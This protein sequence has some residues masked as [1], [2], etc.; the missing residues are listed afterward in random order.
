MIEIEAA[1]GRKFA[2]YQTAPAE[3]AKGTVILLGEGA[4]NFADA[5][6]GNGF[7]ALVPMP[8]VDEGDDALGQAL[9]DVQACV[10]YAKGKGKIAVVG[11]GPGGY[12]AYRAG[13]DVQGIACTIGYYAD[14]VAAD[15][16][17]KCKV[18]T[19]LHF[20]SADYQI[21][22]EDVTQLRFNRPDISVFDY[23]AGHNFDLEGSENY[24]PQAASLAQERTLS[25]VS[26][27]VV[28]QPPVQLKNAGAYAQAKVEKKKKKPA[29]D[30]LGPE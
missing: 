9:A 1:D 29:G 28:G 23:P 3:D 24:N 12:L 20:G 26:Q 4:Q 19:L 15:R 8:P 5:F 2:A 21:P 14:G 18:P 30:D 10:D 13:Y 17:S 7:V 25:W 6:A 27:F 22:F 11:Y 16:R